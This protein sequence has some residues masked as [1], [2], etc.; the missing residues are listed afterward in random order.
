VVASVEARMGSSRL[1]GKVLAKIGQ[2]TVL[3][4]IFERLK[5]C[6]YLQGMVLATSTNSRDD[7]LEDFARHKGVPCFRGSENDVLARVVGA[8]ETM[9]S[10]VIVEVT[11]DCPLLDP[12]LI[13]QGIVTFLHNHCDVVTNCRVPSYPQGVDVQVFRL[14]DLVKVRDSIQ[15]PAVREHVSL[16]FYENSEKY[17]IIN[18][19]APHAL[20]DPDLRLQ[21]DYS[22]DLQLIRVLYD[23]LEPVYGPCFG[24]SEI[25]EL[26]KREP[27]LRKLNADC[28]EKPVR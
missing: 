18:L 24:L 15:D 2:K 11:G 26:L 23:K 13:D 22:E 14:A 28:Q 27:Y 20:R 7:V 19:L 8:H 3:E 12:S 17:R 1:P 21:L 25:L 10:E 9:G 5:A 4:R 16:Y 6:E